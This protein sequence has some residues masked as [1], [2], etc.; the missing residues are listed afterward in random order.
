M[1]PLRGAAQTAAATR[2]A[3]AGIGH[4]FELAFCAAPATASGR[5]TLS[6]PQLGA[7]ATIGA[8]AAASELRPGSRSLARR[9]RSGRRPAM[10]FRLVQSRYQR[11]FLD[12]F[13]DALDLIVRAVQAGLPAPEAIAI[14]TRE[15]RPP[16][17]TEFNRHA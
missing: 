12:A 4:R 10:L 9:R 2:S 3:A 13:P 8:M 1:T 5:C 7:A 14:V 11:H 17:G 15:I 6:P 16:V